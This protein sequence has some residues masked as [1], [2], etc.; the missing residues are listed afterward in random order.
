MLIVIFLFISITIIHANTYI[1]SMF[2][3]QNTGDTHAQSGVGLKLATSINNNLNFFIKPTY[4]YTSKKNELNSEIKYHQ[5]QG[6]LGIEYLYFFNTFPFGFHINGGAGISHIKVEPQN[7]SLG[8]KN[9]E[10]TG[11]GWDIWMGCQYAI[12]QRVVPFLAI[13]YSKSHFRSDSNYSNIGGFGISIG[14][15]YIICGMNKPLFDQYE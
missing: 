14:I 5:M 9:T 13:G 1:D 15:R 8:L 7:K 4:T 2:L 3:Y 12:T 6:L 11:I 10:K